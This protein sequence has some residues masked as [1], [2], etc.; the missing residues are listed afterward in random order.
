MFRPLPSLSNPDKCVNLFNMHFGNM[1]TSLFDMRTSATNSHTT[2]FRVEENFSA[3][4][5]VFG[6]GLQLIPDN[7]NRSRL[8]LDI[9]QTFTIILSSVTQTLD[10]SNLPLT[11]SNFGSLYPP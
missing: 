7:S 10:N 1:M 3:F 5:N 9:V 6:C 4:I 11:R 2:S 8:S